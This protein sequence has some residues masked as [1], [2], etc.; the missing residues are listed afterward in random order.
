MEHDLD[1]AVTAIVDDSDMEEIIQVA[2]QLVAQSQQNS[3]GLS[4]ANS[5]EEDN[6]DYDS[7]DDDDDSK[8]NT[9]HRNKSNTGN[10]S[11]NSSVN[12]NNSKKRLKG[13]VK[14]SH[15]N[16][17]ERK[18]RDLIKDSFTKLKEAVPTLTSERASRAQILK[19]AADFI[20][21]THQRNE[22][23]KND[24]KELMK[25]NAELENKIN[26]SEVKDQ[27][28]A[29]Q[30]EPESKASVVTETSGSKPPKEPTAEIAV[31]LEKEEK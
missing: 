7:D 9:S 11:S 23:V 31:K 13:E 10:V 3:K 12:G 27:K 14:R 26:K 1:R 2:T 29:N 6:M 22:N 19:K 30:N 21:L 25:K 20:Q 15:H 4:M 5:S 16:V 17:L 24:I 8:S 18:R 28:I